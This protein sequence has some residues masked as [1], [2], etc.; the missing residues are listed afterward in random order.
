MN[1]Y[2]NT[3]YNIGN[4]GKV[5]TIVKPEMCENKFWLLYIFKA[6]KIDMTYFPFYK[7]SYVGVLSQITSRSLLWLLSRCEE[8]HFDRIRSRL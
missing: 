5:S 7:S 8:P 3:C 6:L 2:F 1:V 4:N